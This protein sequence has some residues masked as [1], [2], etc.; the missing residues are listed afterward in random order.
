MKYVELVIANNSDTTDQFYTYGC[1]FDDIKVG[2]KVFAPFNRGNKLKEAYVFKVHDELQENIKGLKYIESIDEDICLSEEAISTCVWMKRRYSCRYID[3]I[4]CFTPSG[5]SSKRGKQRR[6]LKDV[7]G[8][9]QYIKE[10]TD[11]QITA[12]D[13]ITPYIKENKH[14][15]FL[16]HGVTGSGKTEIYMQII[17]EC[18]NSS[19]TVIMLV[20]E[21]SLTPQIINRFIGRFGKEDIAVLH[22]K[23][24]L[25]ERYDEWCRI[26][27]GQVKIVIGA[28]SAVFAP[29]ENVGTIILDEEHESTYKSDKTPKYDT[30]EIAIKRVKAQNEKGIVILGSATPSVVSQYRAKEG[31]YELLKLTKRYNEI[32]LPEAT[33]VDMRDE[34]KN[35]NKSV[36]SKALY[37]EM[38][39][40][41]ENGSQV[42][43]FLNRRGYAT[44]VNCRECGYVMQ[45]A[46]CNIAHTYH[47]GKNLAIC[48][49][50]GIKEKMPDSCPECKSKYIR[51]FGVGTEK[52]EEEIKQLFPQYETDRLDLDTIRKKGDIEKVL[53]NF[54]KG[55]TKILV[56]TQLVAKGL[57]FHNVG[58]VG[59]ISADTTLNIPDFRSSE[60]TFQLITQAA[61]RAGRGDKAGKVIIQTY[62]PDHYA[63][64]SA[65][66]HNY[67]QFYE[68][69]ISLRKL[70]KYPPYTD[71]I[72]I[73]IT[74]END[75]EAESAS[76]IVFEEL[77]KKLDDKDRKNIFPP[78]LLTFF[79][80]NG[81]RYQILI[82][83]A[84]GKRNVYLDA[85]SEIKKRIA[86]DKDCAYTVGVDVNP[87]SFI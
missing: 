75:E 18:L 4:N 81:V 53:G 15:I 8:E 37:S 32:E 68:A 70:M 7:P 17:A 49:Y 30:V 71:L 14:N 5:T 54:K 9:A 24:S 34:M 2:Q 60:K 86:S 33:I 77:N 20:P 67:E 47:K 3:A 44:F 40:C 45:C 62:T 87:F 83:S 38:L 10:L 36:L 73:L 42:I 58:L 57:D 12:I 27:N 74:A 28:R 19:K 43:L 72:Q 63:I 76:N 61:G 22:S 48:H 56:G 64:E 84:Q 35:G 16:I 21:I 26:K 1:Q 50:C 25:G 69:E 52:V 79:K 29:L 65:S 39:K 66:K 51:Y 23:L 82:K 11:E 46:D 41:L 6:P 78:Q 85:L 13:K 59:V 31:I 55:K 80:Q